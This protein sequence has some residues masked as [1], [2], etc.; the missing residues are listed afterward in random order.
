MSDEPYVRAPGWRVMAAALIDSAALWPLA[1]RAS[2][3]AAPLN[4][5]AEVVR[6]QVGSPGQRLLG[7]RTVDRRTGERVPLARSL[8]LAATSSAGSLLTRRLA[9]SRAN[10]D[11]QRALEDYWRS[12]RE[13]DARHPDD[14]EAAAA[15]RLALVPPPLAVDI[16]I[17]LAPTVAVALL[18]SVL[19]RRLAPTA[20]VLK[21]P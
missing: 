18:T 2:R 7:V 16:R 11:R 5:L 1:R 12:L 20:Q 10:A 17:A 19:R 4:A 6:E 14:P 15:E 21:R 9:P 3:R 13:I 8:A